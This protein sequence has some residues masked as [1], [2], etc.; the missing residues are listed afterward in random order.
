MHGLHTHE[1]PGHKVT[2]EHTMVDGI[3]ELTDQL[4]GWTAE[5]SL[6]VVKFR[7]SSFLRGRHAFK[8]TSDGIV[9]HPRIEA[10]LARPSR[11]D[12]GSP[13]S[14]SCG[15]DQLDVMLGGGLPASSPP[16]L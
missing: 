5:S 10:L 7:G 1:Q 12:A 9:V 11:P 4:S 8:I 15:I 6:Q 3:I 14:I 13:R 2:P 16:T